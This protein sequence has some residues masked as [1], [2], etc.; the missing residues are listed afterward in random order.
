MTH[1]LMGVNVMEGMYNAAS[2]AIHSGKKIYLAQFPWVIPA[3]DAAAENHC[4]NCD[5]CGRLGLEIMIGGPHD[6][7]SSKK[8]IVKI[9]DRW[10]TH[11][12][13]LFVCPDCNG[14][15]LFSRQAPRPAPVSL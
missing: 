14:S 15:G 12:L 7:A 11:E 10:F 3:P 8:H 4:H 5:G 6:D 1:Q 2:N 13:I 9:D